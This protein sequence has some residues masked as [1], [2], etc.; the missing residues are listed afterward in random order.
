MSFLY[1]VYDDYLIVGTLINYYSKWSQ[2][3]STQYESMTHKIQDL[4]AQQMKIHEVS[5][6]N[7]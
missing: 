2:P 7:I 6:L 5:I 1:E 4:G 3:F